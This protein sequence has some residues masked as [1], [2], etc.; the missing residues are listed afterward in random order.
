MSAAEGC[1]GYGRIWFPQR[2]FEKWDPNKQIDGLIYSR[3]SCR[4][5]SISG[6]FAT[7]GTRVWREESSTKRRGVFV[8]I[9]LHCTSSNALHRKRRILR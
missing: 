8:R 3:G 1:R 9:L 7:Q 2:R 5:G 6:F 4:V